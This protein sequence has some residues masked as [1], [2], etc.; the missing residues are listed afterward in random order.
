MLPRVLA[1][2]VLLSCAPLLRAQPADANLQ[3]LLA[4][5]MNGA[6][7][8]LI[9]P[10]TTGM[11]QVTSFRS[12][13]RMNSADAVA[14]V[15]RAKQELAL[16]GVQQPTTEEIARV[17]AG[18]PMD[19][20]TGHIT[21]AGILNRAG[22][23][24]TITSQIVAAGTPIQG[25]GTSAAG[26]SAPAATSPARDEAIRQL[27]AIGIINP[28]EDQIRIALAGG[29]INTINGPYQLPGVLPR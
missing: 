15:D 14:Y 29:T 23:P 1:A 22:V 27:A 28:S 26:G 12:P 8:T 25:Y 9:T 21:V 7:V 13:A 18:G 11:V 19:L 5:L 17:L 24:A 4:G 20:P 3:N 2:V 16:L 10:L 6:P